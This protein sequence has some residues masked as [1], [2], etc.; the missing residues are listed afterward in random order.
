MTRRDKTAYILAALMVASSLVLLAS[1]ALPGMRVEGGKA[2]TSLPALPILPEAASG[3]SERYSL[4]S[5]R[6]VFVPGRR[7]LP[8]SVA[9]NP[10]VAAP[11][12]IS[13]TLLGV[14]L[15]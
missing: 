7:S 10:V 3:N 8:P 13:L 2:A 1:T 15:K 9:D 6:P 4:L 5:G 11:A 12:A 14:M